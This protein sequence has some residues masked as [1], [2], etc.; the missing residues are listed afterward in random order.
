MTGLILAVFGVGYVCIAMEHKLKINKTATALLTGVLTWVIYIL[1]TPDKDAV[2]FAL[3]EHLGD[4]SSILFFLMGAMTIIEVIDAHN[5]F[6]VI[7][8]HITQ[9]KK[10]TLIWI[11]GFI[12][13]FLSSVLDN[14]TTTIVMISLLRKMINDKDDRMLFA[15][16]VVIAANAGGAWTPIGDVTTTMLWIGGQIST[17]NIMLKLFLPSL[18]CLIVPLAVLSFGMHGYIEP[19]PEA[20]KKPQTLNRK[21]QIVMLVLGLMVLLFVPIFKTY[22]HLPPFMGMLMGLA[23]LWIVTEIMQR[24]NAKNYES[25]EENPY[26]LVHALHRIDMSS[27]L[28]F[29]GILMAVAVLQV[30]GILDHA[31]RWLTEHIANQDVV[32][33]AIGLVS[34]VV[35]NV[36]LVAAAQGM[37]DL[38]LFPMDHTIWELLAYAAGTGGSILI[39]GSA[40]GV[41][42]MGMEK[43]DFVWYL[44]KI[45]FLALLGYFAGAFVYFIQNSLFF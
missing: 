44:K 2:N 28:F 33:M 12:T 1:A 38:A 22:T 36:P 32:I 27:I 13:F 11:V 7:T 17:W 30:S 24:S 8:D 10:R 25:E 39:I 19:R 45:S 20:G 4:V 21:Q 23:V 26:S 41:A 31:S 43:I 3:V 42:A 16:I 15:G 29:L 5:G 35:D 37:Y 40:A 34:A 9:N 6:D 18:V 14:L